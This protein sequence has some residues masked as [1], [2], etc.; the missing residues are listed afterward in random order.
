MSACLDD[1]QLLAFVEGTLDERALASVIDHLDRCDACRRAVAAASPTAEPGA[2]ELGAVAGALVAVGDRVGRFV[3][4]ELLG[5]GGMGEV[6]AAWDPDLD[7]RVALKLVRADLR[8]DHLQAR[9]KREAQ[10]LARLS[11]PSVITIYEVGAFDHGLFLAMELMDGGSLR[12]W[13][14]AAPRAWP[15]IVDHFERAGQGLAAAHDAGLVHRDFKPDNVLLAADGRARVTDFGLARALEPDDRAPAPS[16]WAP[17]SPRVE[18]PL[19]AGL[20]H[21]GA[22]LGTPAYM[23]PEQVRTAAD[24]R[25]DQFSFCASLYQALYGELPF[26]GASLDVYV[27]AIE[28][29]RVRPPPRGTHVPAALRAIVVRGLAAAPDARYPSM[30]ALLAALRRVRRRRRGP[31]V[32]AAALVIAAGGLAIAITPGRAPPCAGMD[33]LLGGVWDEARRRAVRDAFAATHL[34]Y[35]AD[36]AIATVA[37]L[38]ARARA[39]VAMRTTACRDTEARRE[40]ERTRELRYACLDDRREEMRAAIDLL[41]GADAAMVDQVPGVLARLTDLSSCGD[42]RALN[43]RP[44]YRDAAQQAAAR[45][46]D[47]EIDRAVAS[48]AVGRAGALATMQQLATRARAVDYAPTLSTAAYQVGSMASAQGDADGAVAALQESA[49]VSIAARLDSDAEVAWAKLAVVAATSRDHQ[50]LAPTWLAYANAAERGRGDRRD[51]LSAELALDSF[52]VAMARR[53]LSGAEQAIRRNLAIEEQL[54]G[55]DEQVRESRGDLAVVLAFEGRAAEAVPI[56]TQVLTESE[57]AFGALHPT[58]ILAREDAG[59][60]LIVA[61]RPGEALPLL[62]AAHRM[63]ATLGGDDSSEAAID[64]GL[65]GA[66]LEGLGRLDDADADERRAI[67]ILEQQLGPD[68]PVLRQPVATLGAITLERGHADQAVPILERALHLVGASAT[69]PTGPGDVA[70]IQFTLARALGADST[71]ARTLAEGAR[72]TYRELARRHGGD[73][74]DKADEIDRWLATPAP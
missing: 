72:N 24:A 70:E 4:L 57:R 14:R 2:D 61:G 50:A 13:L 23:A 73:N 34:P 68:D 63:R 62:E 48:F 15:E 47:Q 20:T 16:P 17:G 27:A 66:A 41:T 28:A 53:D 30:H 44:S 12:A 35:A 58:T 11:H 40:S 33:A 69:V 64:L 26:E 6:Y 65:I 37:T 10:A 55:R 18:S 59:N 29:G 56:L 3:V 51:D 49:Q 71:R 39:W 42:A 8:A 19:D 67:A 54:G 43:S 25:S 1:D 52:F 5:R 31:I 32:A 74:A 22:V 7:R 9:L 45:A 46:I 36:A 21:A 60:A 38:D